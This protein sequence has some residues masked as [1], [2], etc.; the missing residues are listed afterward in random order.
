[1]SVAGMDAA[2]SVWLGDIHHV[3]YPGT[4]A[5]VDQGGRRMLRMND[6]FGR[7]S[8][9]SGLWVGAAMSTT[10]PGGDDE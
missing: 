6:T 5:G 9:R 1:M 10:V 7:G 3:S 8:P 2:P 4:R